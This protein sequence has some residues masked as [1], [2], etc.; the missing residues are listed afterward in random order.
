MLSFFALGPIKVQIIDLHHLE[1]PTGKTLQRLAGIE[2]HYQQP[3]NKSPINSPVDGFK[4]SV[5]DSTISDDQLLQQNSTESLDSPAYRTS[6]RLVRSPASPKRLPLDI[7]ISQVLGLD[8]ENPPNPITTV[9]TQTNY[10]QSYTY[11]QYSEQYGH[12]PQY[13]QDVLHKDNYIHQQPPNLPKSQSHGG[14]SKVVQI[15]NMLQVVPTEEA[16]PQD[17]KPPTQKIVQVGN[18]LQIVPTPAP[19]ITKEA[20]IPTQVSVSGIVQR[21]TSLGVLQS[22]LSL[23][24]PPPPPPTSVDNIPNTTPTHEKLSPEELMLQ[25]IAERRAERAKRHEER[26]KRRKEKEKRRKEKERKKQ[27]RLKMKTENMIKKALR[28]ETEALAMGENMDDEENEM[29]TTPSCW[30]SV[31]VVSSSPLKAAGKG[32]LI[33][34]GFSKLNIDEDS[35]QKKCKCVKFADGVAPG[36][37]TSP[38]GGEELSSPPPP[39]EK[40]FK[41]IKK[42]K[43]HKKKKIKVK[44]IRKS[45]ADSPDDEELDNLPPPSPPPGSP[46]PHV[47]PARIKTHTN[48]NILPSYA[49]GV[50]LMPVGNYAPQFRPSI[51]VTVPPPIHNLPHHGPS[52]PRPPPQIMSPHGPP[53]HGSMPHGLSPGVPHGIPNHAHGSMHHPSGPRV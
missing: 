20:P 4:R 12:Y 23:S 18:M 30:P 28:I 8:K 10:V 31:S 3:V 21:D 52:T 33:T 45:S 50:P 24:Q 39:K 6:I 38:S 43:I 53:V 14:S 37:G 29:D 36:E 11:D 26:E 42:K 27:L 1:K 19:H 16:P 25:K 5:A 15:G 41:K 7:R 17:H 35:E 2:D 22:S 34:H 46:P 47:F 9:Y 32:I 51:P 40:R 13:N 49:T 48:N 44:I